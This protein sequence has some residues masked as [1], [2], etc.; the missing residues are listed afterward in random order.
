MK[1]LLIIFLLITILSTNAEVITDGTLG[2]QLNLS[3]SNFQIGAD[4]GQQLGGNL[5]HSFQDF[6]LN[7]L[8]IA[9]F[10]GP[11]NVQNI[12]SRVTGGNPSNID[13][14]IRSTI[15]N[16][17]FYFLNPN[18]IVFGPNAQLDVQGS[19]HASTADYLRLGKNG[20]FDAQ[21]PSDSLLT[22]APVEAF[23]FLTNAVAPISFTSKGLIEQNELE[24]DS[25]GLTVLNG[26][27]ISVIGGNIDINKGSYSVET[28]EYYSATTL[29]N[30]NASE[31]RINLVSV[32]S[33]GE[34]I[35]T[36]LGLDVSSFEKMG[37]ISFSN[38]ASINVSGD[39]AGSIFIRGGEFFLINS[40]IQMENQG[41]N[42]SGITDIQVELLLLD[43]SDF[44]ANAY[45]KGKGENINILATDS[46]KLVG[47]D[48]SGYPSSILT[49]TLYEEADGGDAGDISITAR[50][51]SIAD[52]AW[53]GAASFGTGN[54]GDILLHAEEMVNLYGI[55]EVTGGWAT[56]LYTETF[57][58]GNAGQVV[59]EAKN[60]SFKDGAGIIANTWGAGDG[61]SII[62]H[63]SE[64]VE[65]LGGNPYGENQDG[66]GSNISA[67]AKGDGDNVG[68]AGDIFIETGSLAIVDGALIVNSSL[69]NG[70]GGRIIINVAE[71][72][73]IDGDN[74][75]TVLKEPL[76][77]QLEF[78]QGEIW[79][80]NDSSLIIAQPIWRRKMHKSGI[81]SESNS[82]SNGAGNA[83]NITIIANEI[84]LTNNGNISTLAEHA[85][86]GNITL[87]P[88]LL[89]LRQ[90]QITT[91]V[92][93]GTGDGGNIN[94]SN[95]KFTILN[96]GQIIAQADA[97]HGGNIRI[98]AE[99]FITSSDSLI[100]A[101]SNL[102]LDGE[103]EIDSPDMDM[104]GFLVILPG[105]FVDAS[106]LI[107][108]PCNQ[109]TGENVSSFIVNSS[110]GIYNSPNDLLPNGIFLPT[111]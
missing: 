17:D 13:G 73:A 97:G 46:V 27:T 70:Q 14:L 99:Q 5:F 4:L 109:Q 83:G 19:F 34:V 28:D 107:K 66:F 90:G 78:R 36:T 89:F 55:S 62:I 110:E 72:L 52:S 108:T 56:I 91:S 50:N 41:N 6:N 23:G 68:K 103:V 10:F 49:G 15:P 106:N 105:G 80:P 93:G 54:G 3:G 44:F 47:A 60:V 71:T 58:E 43:G 11:N 102:G 76:D 1:Y 104:E 18:G 20:R 33:A 101:S 38:H 16:A 8:E 32:A 85:T 84:N 81:Y 7:S 9:T 45:G 87:I 111:N 64:S 57:S 86:G 22:V 82:E 74:S 98:V 21:N 37:T 53:F 30:L 29:G 65:L 26:K 75:T 39:G 25:Q 35:P 40:T 2:Q 77:S 100:S 61:G 69:G 51:I 92:Q 31:G 48:D 95:P 59:I 79:L 12:I 96:Q 88:N 94:I 67:I 42:D 63:A 24:N